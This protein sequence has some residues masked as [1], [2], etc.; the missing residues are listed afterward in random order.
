MK[1]IEKIEAEQFNPPHQIPEGVCNVVAGRSIKDNNIYF[2][3]EIKTM[4]D[5]WV[6]VKPTDW[7]VKESNVIDRYYSIEDGVFKSK[8]KPITNGEIIKYKIG[9]EE[10]EGFII[11]ND[12]DA[13]SIQKLK[14]DKQLIQSIL[15]KLL[16]AVKQI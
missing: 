8:Y 14:K 11:Y 16:E 5:M 6:E 12:D 9:V 7:I 2:T 3:G 10:I 13:S 15:N 4:K 1:Y